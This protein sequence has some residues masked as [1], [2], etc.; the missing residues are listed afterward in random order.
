MS[1]LLPTF[2]RYSYY[3]TDSNN[4]QT[5]A[6]APASSSQ[7]SGATSASSSSDPS[8][9]TD[10]I[11]VALGSQLSKVVS[12]SLPD[13]GNSIYV[14]LSSEDRDKARFPMASQCTLRLPDTFETVTKIVLTS[15]EVPVSEYNVMKPKLFFSE[16][17][18]SIWVPFSA[19]LSSGNYNISGF[20]DGLAASLTS[21]TAL[22]SEFSSVRNTYTTSYSEEWGLVCITSNRVSPFTLQFRTNPV[23]VTSAKVSATGQYITAIVSDQ[24]QAPLSP[25]AGVTFAPGNGIATLDCVVNAVDIANS[26]VDLRIVPAIIGI[27]NS[28]STP[29][30]GVASTGR[31]VQPRYK[32][33]LTVFGTNT[34]GATIPTSNTSQLIPFSTDATGTNNMADLFGFG[35]QS[36]RT[37]DQIGSSKVAAMQTP[38][39][40]SDGSLIVTTENPHFCNRAD[41]VRISGTGTLLDTIHQVQAALDDTHFQLSPSLK[42]FLNTMPQLIIYTNGDSALPTTFDI[43]SKV[44]L[45]DSVAGVAELRVT[46]K[47][48]S[49]N[50]DAT[51]FAGKT[52][53]F[54]VDQAFYNTPFQAEW[55]YSSAHVGTVTATGG[56]AYPNTMQLFY[57]YPTFVLNTAN[58]TVTR[59]ANSLLTEFT[60]NGTY[61]PRCLISPAR[62]DFS[63][64][65][66]FVYLALTI[67]QKPIGNMLISSLPG[68]RLFAKLPLTSGR[69]AI[70]YLNRYTIEG[71]ATLATAEPTVRDVSI[72]VYNPDGSIYSFQG[73]EASF[74]CQIFCK[75][76][77]Q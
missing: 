64:R 70:T 6:A 66:R 24:Q 3:G 12:S 10:A 2:S 53:K 40:R 32:S 38:F 57:T 29:E 21:A 68:K 23:R 56:S 44:E 42:E 5:A 46:L 9:I 37:S 14:T 48:K 27:A 50:Y 49:A 8:A 45:V 34:P 51:T 52:V 62:Y 36:D 33:L 55:T 65:H 43:V 54:A 15:C 30:I 11:A 47:D 63:R 20:I 71:T 39:S 76:P 7:D 35:T 67:N 22:T 69:D 41:I 74:T 77:I 1:L 59:V 61:Y 72:T 13:Q 28:P 31:V 19:S 16:L 58:A 60:Q 26:T 17:H 25:G 4:K 75:T 73:A 18:E